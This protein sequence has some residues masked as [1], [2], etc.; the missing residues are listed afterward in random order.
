MRRNKSDGYYGTTFDR[1]PDH[2]LRFDD[3]PAISVDI[4]IEARPSRVW[5]LVSDINLPARFSTEFQG[6]DWV[7]DT[8]AVGAIFNGR[9]HHPAIGDW[10]VP[11]YVDTYD[12]DRAFGWRTSD[13]EKPGARWRFELEPKGH[14][15]RLSFSYAIGP[16]R[17]GIS[18]LIQASPENEALILRERI[19]EVRANMRRTIEGIR[20]FA[21]GDR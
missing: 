5:E 19:D 1:V 20:D 8:P 6:A 9:N 16:G 15:T 11:C 4:D 12:T 17:S 21:E 18:M 3:G 10:T 2:E 7:T 13:P 14:G